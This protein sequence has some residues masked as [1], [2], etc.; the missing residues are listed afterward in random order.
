MRLKKLLTDPFLRS[1]GSR[2]SCLVAM[3]KLDA[4]KLKDGLRREDS[5][6]SSVFYR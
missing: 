3:L 1:I 4:A 5:S 2:V 6:F